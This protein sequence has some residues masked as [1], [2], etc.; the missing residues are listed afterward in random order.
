MILSLSTRRIRKR[1]FTGVAISSAKVNVSSR[2]LG[3]VFR[4]FCRMRRPS[5]DGIKDKVKLR[6]IG[7][8]MRLRRKAVHMRDRPK[9]K[10]SFVMQVPVSL[11]VSRR[12]ALTSSASSSQGGLLVIRSGRSFHRFLGRRLSRACR[13]VST[14]SNRRKRGLTIRR[15]PSLVVDSVV[16]PGISK[17]RLYHHVGR[18]MRAS[19]V[20]IVLL[21]TH[22]KSRTG[23]DNCTIKTSSCVSGPFDF[24]ILL[25]HVGR[26]VRRRRNQGG[27]FHGALHIGPD[28]VA[29]ASV[30][31]R[32]L[33]GTLGLV[34][35]RVSGSRCGIR[36]LDASVKVDH[37]GL[38]QGLRTVA[39][40]APARFVHAVHLGQTTRLLRSK[41]LGIS[42]ITSQIKFDSSDCFAGYF[43]RRFNMLPARCSRAS[44]SNGASRGWNFRGHGYI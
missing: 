16:V 42:R 23:V 35:R 21:A 9:G 8:C 2:T 33:R 25:I 12:A 17:L 32:L 34:R 5:S 26:L 24:S 6:L 43:G 37:V 13:M 27:R 39:K 44:R 4:H 29:V 1:S 18:G 10:A 36:R 20:P 11:G 3:R 41:G 31:R 14:P 28:H 40:R 15:G 19:R 22:D 7:R 38:C 30:S